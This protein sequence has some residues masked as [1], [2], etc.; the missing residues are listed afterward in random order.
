MGEHTCQITTDSIALFAVVV[1]RRDTS[2]FLLTV[3]KTG[4][5]G[6]GESHQNKQQ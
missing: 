3:F 1:E 5:A 4:P 6:S 2:K